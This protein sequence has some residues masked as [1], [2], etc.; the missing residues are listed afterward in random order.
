MG[1]IRIAGGAIALAA[2]LAL[3][4]CSG[5]PATPE[6]TAPASAVT[7]APAETP[8]A[9]EAP[10]F[11]AA[12]EEPVTAASPAGTNV[13]AEQVADLRAQ[14]AHV[15][16]FPSGTGDG[17]VVNPGEALPEVVL[18]EAKILTSGG[19]TSA[20]ITQVQVVRQA[21]E[22]AGLQ[23]WVLYRALPAADGAERFVLR[24]AGLEGVREYGQTHPISAD[25]HATR[26]GAIAEMQGLIDAN[27]AAPIIDL[28]V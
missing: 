4:G 25:G 19:G 13:Q 21:L 3:T 5:T 1:T 2:A 9:T 15:Y 20:G 28:T 8:A 7:D 11:E 23:V 12:A 26:E 10:L 14:G 17:I 27:P 6:P 18:T 24:H 16:V 22:D